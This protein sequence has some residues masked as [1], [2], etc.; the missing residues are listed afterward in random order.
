VGPWLETQESRVRAIGLVA[1]G[2]G[3]MSDAPGFFGDY[4]IRLRME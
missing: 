2:E 1:F 3:G 4:R